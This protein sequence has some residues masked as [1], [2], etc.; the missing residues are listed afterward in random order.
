MQMLITF[1]VLTEHSASGT[2]GN[3]AGGSFC[4]FATFYFIGGGGGGVAFTKIH[5]NVG[6]D[7]SIA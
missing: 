4:Q 1:H 3:T 5:V 2:S 7:I 6:N